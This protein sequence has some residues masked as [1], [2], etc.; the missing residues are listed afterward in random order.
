MTVNR[1][2]PITVQGD[3]DALSSLDLAVVGE[4]A[5][6]AAAGEIGQRAAAGEGHEVTVVGDGA[7]VD[8]AGL[9]I[10]RAEGVDQ[11]DAVGAADDVGELVG[12]EHQRG[13]GVDLDLAV[14]GERAGAAAAGEIGQRAAAGEGHRCRRW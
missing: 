9:E 3:A 11:H 10:E 2:H 4:R 8:G 5:G 1:P 6:A 12:V 13:A 7:L 14:V